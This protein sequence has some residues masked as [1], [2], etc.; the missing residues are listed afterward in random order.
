MK[1]AFTTPEIPTGQLRGPLDRGFLPRAFRAFAE[2]ERE[3][4]DRNLKELHADGSLAR[5]NRFIQRM[6]DDR[7]RQFSELQAEFSAMRRDWAWRTLG[8][9]RLWLGRMRR[10]FRP[11]VAAATRSRRQPARR[12]SP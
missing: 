6:L 9:F 3:P 8:V 4:E 12:G 7:D 10:P 5:E 1:P 2:C 11:A